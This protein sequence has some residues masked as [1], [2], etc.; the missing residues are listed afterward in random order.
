MDIQ[1]INLSWLRRQLAVVAQEPVLFSE[2]IFENIALGLGQSSFTASA[3]D[4]LQELVIKAAKTA[5]AHEFIS[6]LPDGYQTRIGERGHGLSS[7]QKQRIAIARAIIRN[8][9]VLILDEATSALDTTSEKIVQA[10]LQSASRGRTTITI[11]HRLSTIHDADNIVVMDAG[12][13]IEQGTHDELMSKKDSVYARLV[14]SQKITDKKSSLERDPEEATSSSYAVIEKVL[15]NT[16]PDEV[17]VR[18][19]EPVAPKIQTQKG[20][21]LANLGYVARLNRREGPFMIV[22]LIGCILAGCLVPA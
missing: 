1:D 13:V 5:N 17:Y 19:E 8:P 2:T 16:N 7:G 9:T 21:F 3:L 10:A 14:H 4:E 18:A 6:A 22:G 15:Q 12:N 20:S 11:A